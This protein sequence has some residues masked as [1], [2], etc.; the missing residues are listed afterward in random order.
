SAG[1]NAPCGEK[2]TWNYK[3]PRKS[4]DFRGFVSLGKD[5]GVESLSNSNSHGYGHTDHGVVAGAQEAH[6]LHVSGDGGGACELSVAVHTAHGVGH[7]VGS[8]AGSHVVRVQGTAG[9]AA[10]SHGEVLLALLNALLLVSAG[11]RVL[12]AGGVGGVAGDGNVH[13]LQVH[14]GDALTDIVGAV[15]AH[16]C[17]LALG[18]GNLAD[19]VDLAGGVVKLGLHV[20][21]AVDAGDDLCS[22][23]AQ[24]VQDNPQGLGTGLVGILH[25]ADGALSSSE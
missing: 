2:M 13:L 1:K 25:D 14:D 15:A 8:G 4:E 6:H 24:T 10:G 12:E 11:N 17:A 3:N 9:A 5:S 21:E 23:L 18:V 16:S 20:G 22:I 19:D 7:A